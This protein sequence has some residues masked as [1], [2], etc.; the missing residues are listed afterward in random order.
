[1]HVGTGGSAG[2]VTAADILLV[3]SATSWS[4][5]PTTVP[6]VNKSCTSP[7]RS[8][9]QLLPLSGRRFIVLLGGAV[10]CPLAARRWDA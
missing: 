9:A 6:E 3:W 10:A 4:T 5:S 8:I 7:E 1:M 2:G